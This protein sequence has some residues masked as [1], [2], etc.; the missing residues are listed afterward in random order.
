MTRAEDN[1]RRLVE[2]GEP[3]KAD[4]LAMIYIVRD[5]L[6]AAGHRLASGY[7]DVIPVG[8]LSFRGPWDPSPGH[9]VGFAVVRWERIDDDPREPLDH[10]RVV[11]VSGRRW[12]HEWEDHVGDMKD[13]VG[14]WSAPFVGRGWREAL[15]AAVVRAVVERVGA[16]R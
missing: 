6:K 12:R 15:A 8:A 3:A 7:D 14:P 16:R 2:G 13:H 9:P 5:G 11:Q 1:V 4:A 10:F